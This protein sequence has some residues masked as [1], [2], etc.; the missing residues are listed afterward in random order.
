MWKSLALGLSVLLLSACAAVSQYSI[1]ENEMEKSLY[2]LLEQ[3]MPRL[4]QGLVETQIDKLDLQIGPDNRDIVRL[5]LTGETAINAFVAR[6]P[7]QLDLIVEGRPVYDRK[8][9]AIFLR[10]LNLIQ[11]KV[12]AYGYKGDAA[13]ASSGIMQMVRSVLENQ[14]VY[15]LDDSRYSWL[16]NAPVGLTIAPGRFILSPKFSD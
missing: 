15:R 12:D 4:T 8:Q 16:K 5:N 13:L 11:S 10:D 2:S 3:E 1:S 6:F 7:A 9:N 14:P